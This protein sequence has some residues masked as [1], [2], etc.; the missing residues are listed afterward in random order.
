MQIDKEWMRQ[1]DDFIILYKVRKSSE[2]IVMMWSKVDRVHK[3]EREDEGG[4]ES[5]WCGVQRR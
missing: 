4:G 5:G 1:V 2:R 3:D